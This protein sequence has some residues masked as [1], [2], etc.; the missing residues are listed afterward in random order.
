MTALWDHYWVIV[1]AALIIGVITGF[2]AFRPPAAG[3]SN[4]EAPKRRGAQSSGFRVLVSLAMGIGAVAAIAAIWH[5]PFGAADRFQSAV[6]KA[7]RAELNRLEM[8]QV[9]AR[10]EREPLTRTLVLSGSADAF[11]RSELVRILD[12]TYGATNVRWSMAPS[13]ATLPLVAEVE[14]FA[15]VSFGLGLL[16]SYLLE[17]RRRSTADWR[18]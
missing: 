8:G 15:I 9:R 13:P 18:W 3:A 14:L 2:I 6:E 17:L 12:Q 1:I 10:L 7:A 11:Q 16:L 5:G 4:S